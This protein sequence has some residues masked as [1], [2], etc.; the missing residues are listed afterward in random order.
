MTPLRLLLRGVLLMASLLAIGWGFEASGLW[1]RLDAAW[2]DSEIRGQGGAGALI[3]IGMGALAIAVGLPRQAVCFLA[4]Y[5]VG[6]GRGLLLAQAASIVGCLL[7]F[8]YARLFGRDLVR[9]HFA[10]RLRRFDIFLSR[11]PL[12]MTMLIRFLPVGSNLVT[13]LLA[14]VSSVPPLPFLAGSLIGYLPQTLIFVLL[15]SGVHV[16]P[17]WRS[18]ASLLLFILSALIGIGLYRRLRDAL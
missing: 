11:H 15:G 17:L 10:E 13:N 1:H 16:Q 9:H 2:V 12:T 3:F 8:S 18:L 6:L 7:C 4:G 14:G 5:A